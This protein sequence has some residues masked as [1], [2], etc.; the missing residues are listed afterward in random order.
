MNIERVKGGK[1]GVEGWVEWW[2]MAKVWKL[3]TAFISNVFF[4]LDERRQQ[5]GEGS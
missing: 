3:S 2:E 1:R 5:K 4:K